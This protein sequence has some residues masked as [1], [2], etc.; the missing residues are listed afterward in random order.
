MLNARSSRATPSQQRRH[1]LHAVASTAR[2]GGGL[3]QLRPTTPII[4]PGRSSRSRSSRQHVARNGRGLC[5]APR[6]RHAGGWGSQA[7]GAHGS[8]HLVLWGQHHS[9]A[10]LHHA[11]GVP[12]AAAAR[13]RRGPSCSAAAEH[14]P[15][16][17]CAGR[18][19]QLCLHRARVRACVRACVQHEGHSAAVS[20]AGEDADPGRVTIRPGSWRPLSAPPSPSSCWPLP[21][22]VRDAVWR[23][24][25]GGGQR[26]GAGRLGPHAGAGHDVARGAQVRAPPAHCC[27]AQRCTPPAPSCPPAAVRSCPAW[28]LSVSRRLP[29]P[30]PLPRRW[31]CE[32]RLPPCTFEFKVRGAG[33]PPGLCLQQPGKRPLCDEQRAPAPEK[34]RTHV[35]RR[36]PLGHGRWLRCWAARSGGSRASTGW[37]R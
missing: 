32:V 18:H 4:G 1:D 28:L 26:A 8:A 13:G 20:C 29:L 31:V 35:R 21:P 6:V 9:S 3:L 5:V 2:A 22:Q 24:P 25:Q 37:C 16:A 27:I 11:A 17:A 33:A 23:V 15:R 12:P 36:V 19:D 10:H 34:P 30:P 14:G 7:L